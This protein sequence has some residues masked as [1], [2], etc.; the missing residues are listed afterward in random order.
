[1]FE[2]IRKAKPKRLFVIADGPKRNSDR[3]S[4]QA[5]RAVVET[6]DWTCEVHRN[7]AD[8]NMGCRARVSS[9]LDWVFESA[10][11]AIILEDDCV[12]NPTFFTFCQSVLERYKNESH[13]MTISG[14]NYQRE[15][16]TVHSYYFS[17]YMHCWGW[18]TWRDAW[19]QFDHKMST[20][21]SVRNQKWLSQIFV[22]RS[23]VSYWRDIFDRVYGNEIDSWAYAWQYSIWMRGGLNVIPEVNLVENIGFGDE[24]THTKSETSVATKASIMDDPIRHPEVLIRHRYADYHTQHNHYE[25]SFAN[26]IVKKIRGWSPL[27]T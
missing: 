15:R 14:T 22:S 18:A 19:R 26:R 3:E 4:C 7:Y 21:P 5:A 16:R 24:A 2:Q 11:R 17:R 8:E 12:P 1:V 27:N 20:W 9:G 10:E 6:V 13:I 23:A 25:T